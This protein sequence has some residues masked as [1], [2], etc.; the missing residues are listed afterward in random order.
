VIPDMVMAGMNGLEILE[1]VKKTNFEI[2]VFILTGHGNMSLA[3]ETLRSGADDFILKPCDADEL[4]IKMGR[5]F[6]KQDLRRKIKIYEDFLPICMYCKQIRDDSG[7]E[8]G[9][10]Q[11][12]QLEQ[13]ICQKS[14]VDLTHGCCPD[15][16]KKHV[17]DY[18]K[19]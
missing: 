17:G 19:K 2:G 7:K 12:M 8:P 4:I 16:F 5:F 11:W 6:E 18:I 10:G 1:K 9:T 3:I 13:Y 15:C 14:G